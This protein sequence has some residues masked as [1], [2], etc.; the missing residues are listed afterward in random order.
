MENR[1]R[2]AAVAVKEILARKRVNKTVTPPE[3]VRW[4]QVHGKRLF[5]WNNNKAAHQHRLAQARIL[6]W[7]LQVIN[8][9]TRVRA[10]YNLRKEFNRGIRG[11][12]ETKQI[13]KDGNLTVVVEEL[14]LRH[15]NLLMQ[16]KFLGNPVKQIL[17]YANEIFD[18]LLVP[19]SVPI[20]RRFT[21]GHF[22]QGHRTAQA[23]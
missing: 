13:I 14:R 6:L 4:D 12:V 10:M 5:N 11:Y 21:A 9:H 7:S 22:K 18:K 17:L 8:D 1:K 20:A 19:I 23:I 2:I 16:Y 3:L 15:Q